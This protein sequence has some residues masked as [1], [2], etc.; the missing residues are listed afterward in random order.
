GGWNEDWT[1]ASECQH[2][3]LSDGGSVVRS[4]TRSAI[5]YTLGRKT[6][7]DTTGGTAY[8]GTV[9]T[10]GGIRTTRA[11]GNRSVSMTTGSAIHRT[12]IS[13]KGITY[14]DYYMV[15]SLTVSGS[16]KNSSSN[17]LTSNRTIGGSLTV[18]HNLLKYTA[19]SQFNSV[20]WTDSSCCYPTSGNIAFTFTGANKPAN[21]ATMAF[22][23]SCGT[24]TL[25]TVTDSGS[26]TSSMTLESC[27]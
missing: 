12:G 6:I 27:E 14:F 15:P 26:F 22:S 2:S 23:S 10:S 5:T 18:Y 9:F 3:Y 7:T 13:R 1:S 19:T 17:L 20:V 21:S 8:D 11:S 25:T 16:L 24:A 4:A